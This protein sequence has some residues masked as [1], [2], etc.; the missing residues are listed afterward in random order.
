MFYL[1][2]SDSQ[3]ETI[4]DEEATRG[5]SDN[6]VNEDVHREGEQVSV[7]EGLTDDASKSDEAKV[8]YCF[9]SA[10]FIALLLCQTVWH[11]TLCS[12]Y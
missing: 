4:L 11:L 2:A 7:A 10:V 1:Q 6:N 3:L 5:F 9:P 12:L 8:C